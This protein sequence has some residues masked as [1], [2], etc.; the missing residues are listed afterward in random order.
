M[1]AAGR[2]GSLWPIDFVQKSTSEE[3]GKWKLAR[4][5]MGGG[6]RPF[7]LTR[8]SFDF[9]EKPVNFFFL[10][11]NLPR[12][13]ANAIKLDVGNYFISK[14]KKRLFDMYPV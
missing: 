3:S 14:G 9:H 10:L 8:D 1:K 13:K 5:K 11:K 6:S 12:A 2:C 4:P 7:N